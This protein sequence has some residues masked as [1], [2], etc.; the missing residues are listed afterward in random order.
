MHSQANIV[1]ELD[2]QCL[3]HTYKRQFPL[4][5]RGAGSYLYD[6]EGNEYL[7]F[8]AGVAVCSVGHCHPLL[9]KRLQEQIGQLMHVSNLYLTEPQARL[10]GRLC[11]LSGMDRAFFCNSGAEACET[12]LKIARKF[13]RR[14]KG[15]Y[16]CE[17]VALN[18]SFHG[19][20]MGALSM[21]GQPKYQ[22]PFEPLVPDILTVPRNDVESLRM[23]VSR[24][25]AA[26]VIEPIQGESGLYPMDKDFLWQA[27]YLCDQ[28]GALL[29][30]DEIQCGMGRTGKWFAWEHVGVMPDVMTLAKGLGGG[31]P[32]GCCLGM[33]EAAGTL[34]PGDHGS[35][36]AGNSMAAVAALTVIEIIE[37][38]NLLANA[39]E[40]GAYLRQSLLAL[41]TE[42]YP[43]QEV[44]GAGLMVGIGLQSPIA[45]TVA[46]RALQLGLLVNPIGDT[47]LRL[48][49]PL[50]ITRDEAE[51]AI[52]LLKQ[53]MQSGV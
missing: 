21:T 50:T 5:V 34:Q 3:M 8:V 12:A 17:I 29:I 53:A 30:F 19:R 9:V 25:T 24:N 35:T 49:P 2:S 14:T 45:H 51:K 36:F 22:E 44:R 16:A 28:F 27:R 46:Q 4:M 43:I 7:D 33:G 52:T 40:M 31:F 38:E 32:I 41:Q 42:G 20:T 26:V 48:V 23:A 1:R 37:S 47:T 39:A 15:G 11:E 6:E 13:A 10:A 18:D